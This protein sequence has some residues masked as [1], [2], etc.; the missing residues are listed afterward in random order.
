[1]FGLGLNES[2]AIILG[3]CA[4]VYIA[5]FVALKRFRKKEHQEKTGI[6]EKG[7]VRFTLEDA[8]VIKQDEI[9]GELEPNVTF[10]KKDILL[11]RGF[12][13]VVGGVN[14]IKEGKYTVLSTEEGINEFTIRRSG[15]VRTYE[16]NSSLILSEGDEITPVSISVI[17][18]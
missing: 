18:R 5:M 15:Y 4:L 11:R 13:Y 17:L 12:K 3:V 16:H 7:G 14:K 2:I 10:D 8:P 6:V 1:M 9:T